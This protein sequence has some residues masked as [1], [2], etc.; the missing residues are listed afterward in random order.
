[1]NL[2]PFEFDQFTVRTLSVDGVVSFVAADVCG[3]IETCERQQ[4]P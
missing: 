3:G 4:S 2:V 1:M